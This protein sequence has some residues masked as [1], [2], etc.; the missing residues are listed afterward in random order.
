MEFLD[1]KIRWSYLGQ[2]AF[3]YGG[4]ALFGLGFI[5]QLLDLFGILSYLNFLVWGWGL[6]VFGSL[7]YSITIFMMYMEFERAYRCSENFEN[8][9]AA[10]QAATRISCAAGMPVAKLQMNEWIL[11]AGEAWASISMAVKPWIAAQWE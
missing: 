3:Y 6:G 5:M 1:W 9:D 8:D 7:V 10:V 11:Y 4:V 2:Y